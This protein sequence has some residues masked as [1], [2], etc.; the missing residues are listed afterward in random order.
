MSRSTCFDYERNVQTNRWSSRY[1]ISF[2]RCDLAGSRTPSHDF[3]WK[4][5]FRAAQCAPTFVTDT[6]IDINIKIKNI[7]NSKEK[8]T[9][10]GTSNIIA[11]PRSTT[12][13]ISLAS[14]GSKVETSKEATTHLVHT[15]VLG[16]KIFRHVWAWNRANYRAVLVQQQ[17]QF[18]A[19]PQPFLHHHHHPISVVV[20]VVVPGY[21]P[22]SNTRKRRDMINLSPSSTPLLFR[23]VGLKK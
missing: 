5:I 22:N 3:F 13:I 14:S 1:L 9:H 21:V 8:Q 20:A 4:I 15:T 17:R 10:C 23:T 19:H 11:V 2:E 6:T 16:H 12:T 18:I 7:I